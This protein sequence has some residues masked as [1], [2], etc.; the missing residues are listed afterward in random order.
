MTPDWRR[1]LPLLAVAGVL[2]VGNLVFFLIYRSSSNERRHAL[3]VRR[4]ELRRSVET[5]ESEARHL[6]AQRERLNGVSSA[7]EE[8]YG[9][10]IGPQR[11]TLTTIVAEV[12]ALLKQEGVAATQIT[13]GTSSVPRLP[14]TQMRVSFPI[15]C[16]YPRFKRLLRDFEADKRWISVRS[17]AINRD[18]EQPGS[19]QVQLELVTYFT[20]A[21]GAAVPETSAG[22]AAP[23]RRAG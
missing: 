6:Q 14:L 10:R 22:V 8:F 13:Y 16:D 18:P 23:T 12:H 2:A 21:P 7:I 11:D 9:R 1:R 19:V 15:R 3:E 5:R 17:V 20:E 4:D